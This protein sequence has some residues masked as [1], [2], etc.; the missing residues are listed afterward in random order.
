MRCTVLSDAL[1]D[2]AEAA[3]VRIIRT[4]VGEV[5]QDGNAVRCGDLRAY[6]LAAADGLH[7]PI[8]RSWF[9]QAGSW[10]SALGIRRHYRIAPWSDTVQVYWARD[11][12][13]YRDPGPMTVSA[14]RY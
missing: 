3:G 14:W 7:S 1:R 6:Y 2:T 5:S 10:S 11:T 12:E 4:D 9:G 8:R 13:A